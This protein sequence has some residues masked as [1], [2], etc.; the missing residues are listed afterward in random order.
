MNGEAPQRDRPAVARQLWANAAE[1]FANL[2]VTGGDA[3]IFQVQRDGQREDLSWRTVAGNARAFG[4]EALAR[5]IRPGEAIAVLAKTRPE[6]MVADM[7]AIGAGMVCAGIYPTEPPQKVAYVVNDARARLIFADTAEQ[8]AKIRAIRDAC[9]TIE[10]VVVLDPDALPADDPTFVGYDAWLESGHARDIAQ[11]GAWVAARAAIRS[12]DVAI[13]IYTSG[14]TGPPKGAMITHR[15]IAYQAANMPGLCRMQPGW[16]RPAF[17]PL[18]HIAERYFTYFSMAA[19]VVSSF[20][21]GPAALLDA[22]DVM[23]PQLVLAVP[24]VFEKLQAAGETWIREQPPAERERLEAAMA[25]ALAGAPRTP[26]MSSAIAEV[27]RAIGLDR[28]EVL[29]SGGAR[30]PVD[31]AHWHAALGTPVRDLYGMTEC[32]TVAINFDGGSTPGLVGAPAPFGDVRLSEVGEILVRGPHVF[33]GY[34]NLPER[35]AEALV[36]GWYHT[37]DVG[38]FDDEGRLI[39]LDRMKDIIISSSGKNITPSEV[40]GALKISPLIADAVAIGEG[41]NYLTALIIID[42]V[43]VGEALAARGEHHASFAEMAA[44]P[45]T[46]ALVEAAVARANSSLSRPENVRRWRIVPRELTAEDDVLTP[47]LKIKRRALAD[48]FASLVQEMYPAH[49]MEAS[50]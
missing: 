2:A 49:A 12:D 3:T 7:A 13:L 36:D 22:L 24:R 28:A 42:P 38:R 50:L 32:G 10:T 11:P 1:M 29:I 25:A 39:L 4:L 40:E 47:T 27:Q 8:V 23:R 37:G 15:N 21:D 43:A 17:L 26:E 5:G 19:G 30:L 41:R 14:T 20:V 9:P 45:T 35:T 48:R 6:W 34:L 46:R 16:T 18:C 44:S 31:L 33:G